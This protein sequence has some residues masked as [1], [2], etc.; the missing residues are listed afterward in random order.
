[1][2]IEKLAKDAAV[3]LAVYPSFTGKEKVKRI[4][5]GVV[6]R[7]KQG[8]AD[9]FSWPNVMLAEGLLAVYR[10]KKD[11]NCLSA[12]IN[13]LKRWKKTGFSIH[14]VDNLMNGSLAF[15]VES[16]IENEKE[17]I[18]GGQ[19]AAEKGNLSLEEQEQIAVLCREVQ[20]V[21][22]EW[23]RKAAKSKRG[24]LY[25]R[26][27]RPNWMFADTVGMISPFLCEYGVKYQDEVILGLGKKQITEF[28]KRGMDETSGLPYHGYDEMTGMKYGIIG[29][30]RA[31]GWLMKGLAESL[32]VL[33]KEDKDYA[34]LEQAFEI[35]VSK[36]AGYQRS[37]GS[38]SW[39]LPAVE[40][41]EDSSAGGMIGSALINAPISWTNP[42]AFARKRSDILKKLEISFEKYAKAGSVEDCSAACRDFAE[43]PQIYGSY[44]WG[45]GSV[46]G[47]L[48]SVSASDY[49]S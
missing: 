24:I 36:A 49:R 9:A 17:L 39:Q 41:H 33:P 21:C 28:L 47:V 44:P 34:Y 48:A 10:T 7:Q 4:I 2:E 20:A 43:Y 16:L 8:P 27:H 3:Q 26:A 40:G 25:Y 19:K 31:C 5:K 15:K 18:T 45:T 29:W 35:L 37:D 23:A 13:Y 30:G 6:L 38:F 1:M 11:E 42:D 32:T 12:V 14:Y 22:A 46:L